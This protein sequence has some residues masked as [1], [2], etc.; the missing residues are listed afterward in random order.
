MRLASIYPAIFI[1]QSC[2][3][4]T[5]VRVKKGYLHNQMISHKTIKSLKWPTCTSEFTHDGTSQLENVYIHVTERH[6]WDLIGID[7]STVVGKCNDA[8][9]SFR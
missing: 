9:G 2:P 5:H 8:N 4:V 6:T 3:T 1:T 7:D